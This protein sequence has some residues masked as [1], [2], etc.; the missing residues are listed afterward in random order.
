MRTLKL[1]YAFLAIVFLISCSNENNKQSYE[2]PSLGETKAQLTEAELK[3]LLRMRDPNNRVSL[4]E[5]MREANWAIDFLNG[6]GSLKSGSNRKVASISTLVSDN[7]KSIAL[8]SSDVDDIEFPDTLAYILN[9]N[10]S[11]GFAIISADTRIDDPL[12]AI[13]ESG[14][15]MDST[16]NPGMAIFLEHL[17]DYML[18]SIVEAEHQY[19]SLIVGILEK[20]GIEI[21]IDIETDTKA[22][23]EE[24]AAAKA[25]ALEAAKAAAQADADQ[26]A[27]EAVHGKVIELVQPLVPVEWL[28]KYTGNENLPPYRDAAQK[29][30]DSA[31]Q[32]IL[33][34][35]ANLM[36]QIGKGV[37]MIYGCSGSKANSG[38]AINFLKK[39]GF[40]VGGL[41]SYNSTNA[42]NSIKRRAIYTTH[43]G[44]HAWVIDGYMKRRKTSNGVNFDYHYIHNNWGWYGGDNGYYSSGVFNSNL[45][46]N[47]SSERTKSSEEIEE[48]SEQYNYKYDIE[49][50][51]YIR[52]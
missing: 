42:I 39:L 12:L 10:D 1:A 34:Q 40:S 8:K 31:S 36:Q 15:L 25:A 16:D 46:P 17:E 29:H 48:S 9:F 13:V 32:P 44:C 22:T 47:F 28:N 41:V 20:L 24:K 52:R 33:D 37:G 21:D 38:D 14:S 3:V 6:E 11:L 45:D 4:D 23:E 30:I 5:A 27:F 26:I 18:N 49:M 7:A 43:D 51:S 2:T 19:D 50:A 35:V